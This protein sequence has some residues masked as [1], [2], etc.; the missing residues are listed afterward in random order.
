MSGMTA[1]YCSTLWNELVEIILQFNKVICMWVTD[2][3]LCFSSVRVLKATDENFTFHSV[4]YKRV[5][6]SV[7]LSSRI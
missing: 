7:S 3:F 4:S 6:D 5:K 2:S 1:Q